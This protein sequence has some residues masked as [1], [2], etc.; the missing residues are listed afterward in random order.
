[1]RAEQVSG[2]SNEITAMSEVHSLGIILYEL[3]TGRLPYDFGNNSIA[4]AE[5][6]CL[7]AFLS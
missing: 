5:P 6:I 3:L 1:M 4:E 7:I 2:A